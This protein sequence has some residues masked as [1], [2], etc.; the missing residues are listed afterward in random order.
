MKPAAC[1]ALL[2]SAWLLISLASGCQPRTAVYEF[3]SGPSDEYIS[4]VQNY[5]SD[6]LVL[7]NALAVRDGQLTAEEKGHAISAVNKIFSDPLC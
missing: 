7:Q 1:L 4:Y 5:Q 6:P 2:G 3:L